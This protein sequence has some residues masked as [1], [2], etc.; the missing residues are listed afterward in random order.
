M[1]GWIVHW[2]W[3]HCAEVLVRQW[4]NW[5]SWRDCHSS[6]R[7]TVH[8]RFTGINNKK[9]HSAAALLL[10]TWLTLSTAS[11]AKTDL[12]V[13]IIINWD[14]VRSFWRISSSSSDYLC[15]QFLPCVFNLHNCVISRVLSLTLAP[16]WTKNVF[17]F[18]GSRSPFG[19]VCESCKYFFIKK[20]CNTLDQW[21]VVARC[22][23]KSLF[24]NHKTTFGCFNFI[25]FLT[26]WRI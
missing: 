3:R 18:P 26:K 22:S 10:L 2:L 14:H 5:A 9:S 11:C 19:K 1:L 25:F 16:R 17:K 4:S 23:V 6:L 7:C 21:S 15:P 13:Q 12:H 24:K 20:Y 8:Q